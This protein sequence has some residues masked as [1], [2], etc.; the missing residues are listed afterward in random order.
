MADP[1]QP[2]FS[3]SPSNEVQ[4]TLGQQSFAV[5]TLI[6]TDGN[7]T[8]IRKF[9]KLTYSIDGGE[10]LKD[11]TGAKDSVDAGG[12][13]FYVDTKTGTN[14]NTSTGAVRIGNKSTGKVK[15]NVTATVSDLYKDKY[16]TG[17]TSYTIDIIAPT[18]FSLK[19]NYDGSQLA[20]TDTLKLMTYTAYG[21]IQS[22]DV[23]I[24]KS[25]LKVVYLANSREVDCTS[26]FTITPTVNNS[27][28]TITSDSKSYTLRSTLNSTVKDGLT[29]TFTATTTEAATARYGAQTLTFTVHLKSTY[30]DGTNKIKTYIVFE[31]PEQTKYKYVEKGLDD[32]YYKKSIEKAGDAFYI[33]R[34]KVYDEFGNDVTQYYN[35][36]YWKMADL[37]KNMNVY[38]KYSD[39]PFDYGRD[40]KDPSTGKSYEIRG[41]INYDNIR[42]STSIPE[43]RLNIYGADNAQCGYV[44]DY[45]LTG[46]ATN[47]SYGQGLGGLLADTASYKSQDGKAQNIKGQFYAYNHENT[48]N[49]QK[50]Q[51]VLHVIKRTPQIV[52]DPDP[53]TVGIAKN[54][55]MKAMNRF[56]VKGRFIDE[57]IGDT[58]NIDSYDEQQKQGNTDNYFTYAFFVP[59]DKQFGITKLTEFDTE[60]LISKE[61]S[62]AKEEY[63]NNHPGEVLVEARFPNEMQI[64]NVEVTQPVYNTDGT[65]ALN[66]DGTQKYDKMTGTI[67]TAM[68]GD[69]RDTLW[70]ITF[71]GT[72]KIPLYYY[73]IPWTSQKWD[74]SSSEAR[75]YSVVNQ[76]KVKIVVDPR[77]L[78]M[79]LHE[80]AGPPS[81]KVEDLF[82]K[83]LTKYYTLTWNAESQNHISFNT[84]THVSTGNIIGG[85]DVV[86]ITANQVT[87]SDDVDKTWQKEGYNYRNYA[88]T[89]Y[90]QEDWTDDNGGSHT[91]E[92]YYENYVVTDRVYYEVIYDDDYYYKKDGEIQ[93]ATSKDDDGNDVKNPIPY[94]R[95]A[96]TS[97]M[98]KLHFINN[99]SDYDPTKDYDFA[100]GQTVVGEAPGVNITFGEG[101]DDTP[102]V[103]EHSPLIPNDADAYDGKFDK[104]GAIVVKSTAAQFGSSVNDDATVDY[105]TPDKKVLVS[106]GAVKLQ[107]TTNGFLQI[108]GNYGTAESPVEYVLADVTGNEILFDKVG[109]PSSVGEATTDPADYSSTDA[110]IDKP[111]LK[112]TSDGV[113]YGDQRFRYALLEGHTYYLYSTDNTFILHGLT[114]MPGYVVMREDAN[115]AHKGTIFADNGFSGDLP[116]VVEDKQ[117]NV[118]FSRTWNDDD[119]SYSYTST[120][121]SETNNA[122]DVLAIRNGYQFIGKSYTK[123]GKRVRV[124]ASVK[125][126]NRTGETLTYNDNGTEQT[127]QLGQV[128]RAPYMDIAVVGIPIYKVGED[129]AGAEPGDRVSTTNF[130]TR[131]WMTWGGWTQTDQSKYPYYKDMKYTSDQ[132]AD[133]WKTPEPIDSV[134]MNNA[135][136]DGFKYA[137]NASQNP[138]DENGNAWKRNYSKSTTNLMSTFNLPVRGGYVKFEPEESGTLMVYVLQPGMTDLTSYDNRKEDMSNPDQ[139]RRRALYI[140]DEKGSAVNILNKSNT[141]GE[142]DISGAFS[143]NESTNTENPNVDHKDYFT[144]G[145]LRCAFNRPITGGK[146]FNFN[147]WKS[148]YKSTNDFNDD[149]NTVTNAWKDIAVGSIEPLIRLKD[150]SYVVPTKAFVRYTF[151]VKSGKT[152]Y[153]WL[154]GS[155]LNFCGFAFVPTGF[156][157]RNESNEWPS[158]SES[159]DEAAITTKRNAL[160][161]PTASIYN[162]GGIGTGAGLDDQNFHEGSDANKK[163]NTIADSSVGDIAKN[164]LGDASVNFVNVKLD[165]KFKNNEWTSIC[166]PFSLNQTQVQSI[167]GKDCSVIV[168]DSVMTKH[169]VTTNFAGTNTENVEARTAHFTRHVNQLI[170]AGRP[171]FIKPVFDDG[172]DSK[173][174]I[175]F[176][177]VSLEAVKPKTIVCNNEDA[178]AVVAKVNNILDSVENGLKTLTDDQL[179]ALNKLK[180]DKQIFT[181]RFTGQYDYSQIPWYSYVMGTAEKG[182]GLYRVVPTAGNDAAD[183]EKPYLRGF[184]AYLYPYAFEDGSLVET[185]TSSAA[186]VAALWLTGADVFGDNSGATDDIDQLVADMNATLTYGVK[187]VFNVAGQMVRQDN[188]LNG[189]PAGVYIMNGKKYLV[190]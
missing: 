180:A 5:P 176:K 146:N 3:F 14:V 124:R 152:Y 126:K 16:A 147:Q 19:V 182:N 181:Y 37:V 159:D 82:G 170:E 74:L 91:R 62:T 171:Y 47:N 121:S 113:M 156:M 169:T 189:L 157:S 30:Y 107:P 55:T 40:M 58:V 112:E 43:R 153:V 173:S 7:G 75:I 119:W 155:K 127:L 177:H 140:V 34:P 32:S 144:E 132:L 158:I 101:S 114:F 35:I 41:L 117:D 17:S 145:L 36:E 63:L 190:K 129:F 46:V 162:H 120:G 59:N 187:G 79:R 10:L 106:G 95:H 13:K 54:Y 50:G 66:E 73:F 136:I 139:L 164:A 84:D 15:V 67:Y 99:E 186:K 104:H 165:R 134:G 108:D 56:N 28:I 51:Y 133:V 11:Y 9:Y 78:T 102:W 53:S 163:A 130:V 31:Q 72:G 98:G 71:H 185:N 138:V 167:F 22:N 149:V 6:I 27:G 76:E 38:P 93:Y 21:S 60:N 29:L 128:E 4:A 154:S 105:P 172:S 44:D 118:T 151:A 109:R 125:G 142:T 100:T 20:D 39:N 161:E 94:R 88:L 77:S 166:L 97:K 80:T 135:T 143:E 87:P 33:Q 64:K 24:N 179:A 150:S 103:I 96:W 48:Y 92:N 168:F 81:V 2:Q 110:T 26:D 65:P 116:A 178:Q 52:L 49:I 111:V 69:G 86:S 115:S 68:L 45:I 188:N 12:N 175:E 23:K 131:I 1:E 122:N 61:D 89:P 148:N 85:P 184:R 25:D 137:S 90:N 57:Y 160:P 83:D 174:N 183:A 123:S 42:D 18:T 8:R 141:W 70:S